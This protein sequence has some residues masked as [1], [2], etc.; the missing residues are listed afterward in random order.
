MLL[1]ALTGG[2]ATGKTYVRAR[3]AA[4]GVPTIDA[5]AVVH[6]L[7][8]PGQPAAGAI[9]SRFG[10]AFVRADGSV[11][12]TA[13]GRLVFDDAAARAEL[14]AIVHPLVYARIGEWAAEQRRRKLA[15]VVADIPLLFE[16]GREA[17]FDAVIVTCCGRDLQLRRLQDRDGVGEADAHARLAAQWPIEDKTRRADYVIRTDGPFEDTDRQVEAVM[18][19]INGRIADDTRPAHRPPPTAH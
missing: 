8:A 10:P 6:E 4:R 19:A 2:I 9:A 12:R 13:L 7:M 1:V 15:W 5:D 18:A 14:E 17:E 3:I 11:D 16:T